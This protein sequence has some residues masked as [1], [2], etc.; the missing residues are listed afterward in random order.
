MFVRLLAICALALGAL[1][2]PA[3]AANPYPGKSYVGPAPKGGEE[4]SLVV[5]RSGK[6]VVRLNF[7]YERG[8]RMK[9]KPLDSSIAIGVRDVAIKKGRFTW[10]RSIRY[11]QTGGWLKTKVTGRFIGDGTRMKGTLRERLANP[12][13]GLRCDSG[14][15]RFSGKVPPL[16]L[17]EGDWEGST[18]QNRLLALSIRGSQIRKLDFEVVLDCEDGKQ[19]TRRMPALDEPGYLNSDFSFRLYAFEPTSFTVTGQAERGLVAG[20]ITASEFIEPPASDPDANGVMCR[21][22]DLTFEARPTF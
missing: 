22:G 3:L 11:P 20:T 10:K 6:K 12:Q 17:L 14:K 5:S 21:S 1:A 7:G 2:T 16:E 9:G 13:N 15:V 4:V 19:I 18:S 8:C